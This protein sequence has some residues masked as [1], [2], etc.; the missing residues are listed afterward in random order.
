MRFLM[1]DYHYNPNYIHH[2]N[3]AINSTLRE[4]VFGVEDGM[5]STMGAVTGIATGTGNH[6][7]VVLSGFVI[8]AVESISMAVGSYISNK[9][10][11]EMKRRMIAEEKEEIR[12]HPVEEQEEM[13]RLFVKD[14]WPETLA[15]EMASQTGKDKKLMLKEMAYR[16]LH[17]IPEGYGAPVK[18]GLTMLFSYVFGGAI[19]LAPYLFFEIEV[20]LVVSITATL[21]G[22]FILG[23][24]TTKFSHRKWWK[25]GLE[26]LLLAG[27]AA[28]VGYAVGS[29]GDSL[30]RE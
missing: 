21:I 3:S 9:S 13:V 22:L 23:V 29:L 19:P 24:F 15:Q 1:S 8:I 11:V 14:G 10:E 27:A 4:L 25:A 6:I 7:I 16:E 20:A 26:M 30:L 2:K 18:E 12:D 17:I 28:G 5:V